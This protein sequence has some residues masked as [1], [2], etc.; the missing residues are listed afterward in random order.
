MGRKKWRTKEQANEYQKNYY[1]NNREKYLKYFKNYRDAHKRKYDTEQMRNYRKKAG[2]KRQK[3]RLKLKEGKK[4]ER[5]GY[6]EHTEILHFHHN[7]GD[8]KNSI[9]NARTERE[10]LEEVKKCILI[11]PNCHAVEHI[12]RHYRDWKN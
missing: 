12:K 3:L 10:I 6:S 7:N 1:K 4:C 11:C 5:C 8:K 2:D 9:S